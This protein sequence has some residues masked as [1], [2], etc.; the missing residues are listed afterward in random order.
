MY[1]DYEMSQTADA[2]LESPNGRRCERLVAVG[3]FRSTVG[4]ARRGRPRLG[5]V[6]LKLHE[7][8]P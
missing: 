3:T 1:L 4:A 2:R 8:S 7:C 6:E 5:Q